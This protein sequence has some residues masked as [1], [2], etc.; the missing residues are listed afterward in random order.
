MYLNQPK[1]NI[2]HTT[3][4]PKMA[5]NHKISIYFST[6]TFLALS[7]PTMT[8]KFKMDWFPN[9]GCYIELESVKHINLIL[10]I[11]DEDKTFN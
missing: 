9:E 6:N 8:P 10:L 3:W 5:K 2:L 7:C 1:D 11:P 4:T